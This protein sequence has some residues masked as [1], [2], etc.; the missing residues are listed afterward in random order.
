M[1]KL[2]LILLATGISFHVEAQDS[3]G[4]IPMEQNGPL[5]SSE[6]D[7]IEEVLGRS[8]VKQTPV[9]LKPEQSSSSQPE[10]PQLSNLADIRD[11]AVIQ[12]RFLP[13][14][15]RFQL[16]G[17][18][19]NTVNDPWFNNFGIQ[20]R[21]SYGF[22]EAFG[23][24]GSFMYLTS[25]EKEIA[26][27]L[28][29]ETGVATSSQISIKGY[30]GLHLLWTPIYGKTALNNRR[31]IPFDMYFSFGGGQTQIGNGTGGGTV[32]LGTGQNYAL[33]KN[34]SVNWDFSW[35]IFSAKTDRLATNSTQ[36]Y[37][38]LILTVGYSIFFPEAKYR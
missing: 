19:A 18:L 1:I 2:F 31:I 17:S 15:Q 22:T 24:E 28:A 12:R 8:Q 26:K 34:S 10:L 11:I 14:T 7:Q 36:T 27:Y 33:T 9:L 16:T 3:T 13:K 35:N 32:H 5:E 37:N 4:E 25:A 38:N 23:L 20:A 30:S 29:S 6:I 21:L